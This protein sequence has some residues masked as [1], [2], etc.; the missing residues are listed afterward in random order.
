MDWQTQDSAAEPEAALNIALCRRA[1]NRVSSGTSGTRELQ[2]DWQKYSIQ[3][4]R[5]ARWKRCAAC[6]L[7]E[8]APTKESL[9]TARRHLLHVRHLP[10]WHVQMRSAPASAMECLMHAANM[11][12]LAWELHMGS[13][14]WQR[15]YTARSCHHLCSAAVALHD[16]VHTVLCTH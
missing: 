4:A 10:V 15:Q 2:A 3:A 7:L 6:A 12:C 14:L 16:D 1:R 8:G 11:T 9:D 13:A 5:Q